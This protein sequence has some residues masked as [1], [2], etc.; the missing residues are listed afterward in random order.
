MEL[1]D[2][3]DELIEKIEDLPDEVPI[4]TTKQK[5][6]NEFP[7]S[8]CNTQRILELLFP[9]VKNTRRSENENSS[10]VSRFSAY[11]HKKLE[12]LRNAGILVTHSKE[13]SQ[14]ILYYLNIE[15]KNKIKKK[16]KRDKEKI[17]RVQDK[18]VDDYEN[19]KL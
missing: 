14:E 8:T 5:N 13:N 9:N 11:Y 3:L 6:E 7:N 16:I 10:S 4:I 17:R 2:E 1:V 15:T 12:K 18:F 19:G